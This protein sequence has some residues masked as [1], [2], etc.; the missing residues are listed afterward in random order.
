MRENLV[1]VGLDDSPSA[2][3]A[4]EWA[5]DYARMT[6]YR[7]V[8][9]HVTPA[10]R[11][12]G[13]A[14]RRPES[15]GAGSIGAGS[16]GAG[17]I[18]AGSIGAGSTGEGRFRRIERMFDSVAPEHD[19]Q[20]IR[21]T[22]RPGEALVREAERAVLLVIGSQGHTGL[23]RLLEGS[24]SQYCLRHSKVPV[25]SYSGPVSPAPVPAPNGHRT[26]LEPTALDRITARP[27]AYQR[28]S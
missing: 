20:L 4:L 7:V 24:V 8:A 5:A 21:L 1:V 13:Y 14:A 15:T 10:G 26:F 27:A 17:S 2:R 16:I 18:D 3:A 9:V 28:S 6:D 22:G 23:N 19:W 12:H 11:P 25:L